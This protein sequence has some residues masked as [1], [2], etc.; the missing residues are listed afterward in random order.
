[1][2]TITSQSSYQYN[3]TINTEH[4]TQAV[5]WT[6]SAASFSRRGEAP[7]CKISM[8]LYTLG[9]LHNLNNQPIRGRLTEAHLRIVTNDCTINIQC[10]ILFTSGVIF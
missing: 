5:S 6:Y 9:T 10:K 3:Q 2:A 7:F 4:S 8:V 1:M